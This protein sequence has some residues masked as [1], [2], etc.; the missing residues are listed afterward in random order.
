MFD[1]CNFEP[2]PLWISL[3]FVI[4]FVIYTVVGSFLLEKF[5]AAVKKK[6]KH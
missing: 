5:F 3:I 1:W 2:T 4:V 6:K